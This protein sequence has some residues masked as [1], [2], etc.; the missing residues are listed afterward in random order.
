M[1]D[2][3]AF[4]SQGLCFMYKADMPR[5]AFTVFSLYLLTGKIWHFFFGNKW[6]PEA[7]QSPWKTYSMNGI[8]EPR[9]LTTTGFRHS[10][11]HTFPTISLTDVSSAH[12]CRHI[13]I[14]M[15]RTLVQAPSYRILGQLQLQHVFCWQICPFFMT[16]RRCQRSDSSTTILSL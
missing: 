14:C 15:W 4:N 16:C 9:M 8:T 1:G 5:S 7:T 2:S 11:G 6:T 3:N 10:P 12:F 13:C